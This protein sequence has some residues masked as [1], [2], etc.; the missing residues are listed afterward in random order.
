MIL[1][2]N[3]DRVKLLEKLIKGGTGL[4]EVINMSKKIDKCRKARPGNDVEDEVDWNI[5]DNIMQIK[6]TDA[7]KHLIEFEHAN[8]VEQDKVKELYGTKNRQY[9]RWR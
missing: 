1:R 4:N 5:V 9:R 8:K 3:R 6:L 2:T 7:K